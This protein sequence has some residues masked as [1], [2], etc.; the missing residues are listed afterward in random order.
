[1]QAYVVLGVSKSASEKEIKSAFRKLA[2]KFHPDQNKEDP[3]AQQ[4]FAE[5]NQAYEILGDKAKRQQFDRG[6]IDAEGKEKFAGFGQGGFHPGGGGAQGGFGP[7]MS[8][9]EDIMSELFGSAFGGAGQNAGFGGQGSGPQ[10]F[11]PQGFGN[12]GFSRQATPDLD[13]KLKAAVSVEDL[14]RG[15]TSV[16]MPDGKQVSVSIPAGAEDGKTIRLKGQIRGCFGNPGVQKTPGVYRSGNRPALS[17]APA[18]GNCCTGRQSPGDN[19]GW[20]T[21]A[22]NSTTHEFRQGIQAER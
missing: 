14:A 10:G 8:G 16:R 2:K 11:G 22:N 7:G 6:E 21:V 9:A 4:R 17:T 15:K 19:G 3:K 20:E 5:A 13:I 12:H 1:M 18:A